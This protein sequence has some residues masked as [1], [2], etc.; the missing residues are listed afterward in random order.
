MQEIQQTERKRGIS[1]FNGVGYRVDFTPM[2]DM[3][4]LLLTFFMLATSLF[5]PNS[6][7]INMPT[8]E[9]TQ[10]PTVLTASKAVTL[11]LGKDHQIYYFFG[12]PNVKTLN[13]LS[14]TNFS[15]AGLRTL[16]FEKNAVPIKMLSEL[17]THK[18]NMKISREQLESEIKK[19]KDDSPVVLIKPLDNSTYDD[20]VKALNEMLVTDISRYMIARLDAND[21]IMLKKSGVLLN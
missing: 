11:Y 19:I 7:K 4:M 20:M 15:P 17:E 3:N 12:E 10:H 16:L 2:V 1:R 6:M 21:K 18:R 5:K 8:N 9:I 13:F 14:K